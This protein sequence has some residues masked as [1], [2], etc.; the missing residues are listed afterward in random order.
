M[1]IVIIA[2]VCLAIAF[3]FDLTSFYRI[4]LLYGVRGRYKPTILRYACLVFIVFAGIYFN[5][6]GNS[7]GPA[8]LLVVLAVWA[9][10]MM[11]DVKGQKASEVS[12]GD[13]R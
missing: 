9:Y 3:V 13:R 7:D 2:I 8:I 6:S 5:R 11:R 12:T 10:A 1:L 4:A